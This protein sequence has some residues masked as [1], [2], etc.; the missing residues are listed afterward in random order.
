MWRRVA[1]KKCITERNVEAPK[2]NK[3]SS[4]SAHV[5]GMDELINE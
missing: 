2:N 4:Y 1:G 3:K 5:N